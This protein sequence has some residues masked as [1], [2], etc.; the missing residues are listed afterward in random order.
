MPGKNIILIKGITGVMVAFFFLS[1]SIMHAQTDWEKW[2]KAEASYVI[3]K[4]QYA[5]ET[6]VENPGLAAGALSIV[7]EVYAF[8]ISDHDGDNCPFYP[9]C[10]NFYIQA[11]KE[12][13]IIKG[14]LMFADRFTRD[15]NLLKSPAHYPLH[16]S[17]RFYDPPWNYTLVEDNIIYTPSETTVKK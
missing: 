7:R 13:G 4:P 15:L 1:A 3:A 8:F 12:G 2:G 17:G 6:K 11:V 5:D 14:T 9:S 10:S 16:I